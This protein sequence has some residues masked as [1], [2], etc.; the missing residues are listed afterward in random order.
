MNG[1]QQFSPF[2]L[3]GK[4][5]Q[6]YLLFMISLGTLLLVKIILMKRMKN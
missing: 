5:L 2:H 1:M 6:H 3:A 4:V